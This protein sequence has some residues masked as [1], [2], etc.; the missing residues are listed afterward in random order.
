MMSAIASGNLNV[1]ISG[2]FDGD[3]LQLKK[4]ANATADKLAEIV[5]QTVEGVNAI[6]SA[7]SRLADGADDLSAR[8][9]KQAADLTEM[10]GATRELAVTLQK[11]AAN[12]QQASN[13]AE[14]A[15]KA[16]EDGGE[17]TMAAIN[18]VAGIESSSSR[19]G[20]IVGMIQDIASQTNLLAL[21]AAVE[22]ARAG[23]AGRGFAVVAAE[24]RELAQRTAQASKDIRAL[25]DDSSAQVRA[26]V[27]FVTKAGTALSAIVTSTKHAA[28]IVS[29]IAAASGEQAT[30]IRNAD[31]SVGRMEA[32]TLQNTRLVEH[33]TASLA[34]VDQ[35]IQTLFDLISFF[36][37]V[38]AGQSTAPM[39]AADKI[40]PIR[41]ST[42]VAVRS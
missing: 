18:A 1:R 24:V 33:T 2:K 36:D 4:D 29:Q 14:E 42:A 20:E 13:L 22:A 16:A 37:A 26:G 6:R 25:V 35:Q 19:I 41:R 7:T 21:N 12:A 32:A 27:E 5:G 28:D 15:R 23:D 10:A 8:T 38:G 34:A 3:L 11:T 31:E 30:E 17:I 39:S 40:V 9:E